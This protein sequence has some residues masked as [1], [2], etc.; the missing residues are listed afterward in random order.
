M[1][2]PNKRIIGGKYRDIIFAAGLFVVFDMGVLI[3]NFYTSFEIA[4]DATAINLAGRQR[5]L[6]Q[7][8]TKTLLQTE[9]AVTTEEQARALSEL[10]LTANLFGDTFTAFKQGGTTQNTDNTPIVLSPV[11]DTEAQTF[12][13]D[14]ESIW[15]PLQSNIKQLTDNPNDE[16]ALSSALALANSKNLS[17]LKLMNQLTTR[18][19]A[20]AQQKAER[21][22]MIQTIGITLALINFGLLLFHFIRKLGRSD[23]AADQARRETEE[24]LDTVNDGFFLVDEKLNLGHQQ[25]T[26]LSTIF[27]QEIKAETPFLDLLSNKVSQSTMNTAK[28]YLELLFTKRVR[29]NLATDLNPLINLEIDLSNSANQQ[30]IHYLNIAFKRVQS[31]ERISHLMGTVTDVTKQIL[32]ERSLEA[33]ET[34]SQ[35]EMELLSQILQGDPQ[36]LQEHLQ[37]SKTLLLS[38]NSL[39]ENSSNTRDYADIIKN[40]LPAVHKIK[41]DAGAIGSSAFVTL[42][43]ELEEIMKTVNNNPGAT[44]Q[45]LLPITVHINEMLAKIT[46]VEK[47]TQKILSLS[48]S[49]GAPASSPSQR[50][51]RDFNTLI[52]TINNDTGKQTKLEFLHNNMERI[53][54]TPSSY[55]R[56]ICIQMIRNA[57]VHGIETPDHR[58]QAGKSAAGKIIIQL[59]ATSDQTRLI[60]R[61]DGEGLSPEK[62]RRSLL[63]KGIYNQAQ[64]D[65]LDDK[66]IIMTIFKN[67]LSTAEQVSEH[68]GQGVGLSVVREAIKQLDGHL[69]IG[70]KPGQ[71]TEFRMTFKNVQ[72]TQ[73]AEEKAA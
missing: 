39:L 8:M 27:K 24:I 15:T 64:L 28:E 41:G 3:L 12:L 14:A 55:L 49:S 70:S 57:A 48:G 66:A 62:I 36:S 52:T 51:N 45:D 40:N 13:K 20:L 37:D 21:L 10:E 34:R 35:E 17:L 26:A 71:Y 53:D 54:K 32:L 50:W 44:S 2:T 68:A 42:A 16:D 31:E 4:K 46:M 25:S 5:M 61:D 65:E 38:I 67:G 1:N 9:T 19:A 11:D 29:E 56:D 30:D 69:S 18:L 22:R 6:S 23:A 73:Q 58:L 7:R 59:S 60:I 47:I 63:N 72:L 43:H 33:A